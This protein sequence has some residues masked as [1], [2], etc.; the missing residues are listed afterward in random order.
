MT[1]ALPEEGTRSQPQ[2]QHWR[3]HSERAP[4]RLLRAA[5]DLVHAECVHGSDDGPFESLV[6]LKEGG[7]VGVLSYQGDNDGGKQAVLCSS[8]EGDGRE[9]GSGK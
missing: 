2:N 4:V 7:R 8:C 1:S 5:K 6:A 9:G 3:G